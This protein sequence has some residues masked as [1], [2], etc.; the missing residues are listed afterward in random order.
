MTVRSVCVCVYVCVCSGQHVPETL[1]YGVSSFVLRARRPFHP[2]RLAD[3]LDSE[4]FTVRAVR[5][6]C[7]SWS[8]LFVFLKHRDVVCI[9]LPVHDMFVVQPVVRSKGFVWIASHHDWQFLWSHAGKL[10]NIQPSP[11]GWSLVCARRPLRTAADLLVF[12][13]SVF[14]VLVVVVIVRSTGRGVAWR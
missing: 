1:E 3:F 10:H 14:F 7:F 4:D 5:L 2:Q 11:N 13:P 9:P 6:L 8:V 12:F